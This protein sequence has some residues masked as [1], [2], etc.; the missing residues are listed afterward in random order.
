[1]RPEGPGAKKKNNPKRQ[2]PGGALNAP[3]GL[4]RKEE[5]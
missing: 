1:M 4:Q 2:E 3:G 5:E